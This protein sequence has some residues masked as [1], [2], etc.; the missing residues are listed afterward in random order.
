MSLS[1]CEGAQ[2]SRTAY[3]QTVAD[4]EVLQVDCR[5][6]RG[7]VRNRGILVQEVGREGGAVV[8]PVPTSPVASAGAHGQDAQGM[9]Y[10][11]V[12]I[13]NSFFA[14]LLKRVSAKKIWRNCGTKCV[15]LSTNPAHCEERGFITVYMSD[16]ACWEVPT[17]VVP[18]ENPTPTG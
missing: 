12:Q 8:P 9:A 4:A 6:G 16:A 1:K 7:A 2:S 10:D 15:S 5:A 17:D 13:A 14:Y 11:S 18:C 3:R